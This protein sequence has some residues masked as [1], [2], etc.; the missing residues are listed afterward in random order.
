MFYLT[1]DSSEKYISSEKKFRQ[2]CQNCIL[3]VREI[4]DD[5]FFQNVFFFNL[6]WYL[7]EDF[8]SFFEIFQQNCQKWV[9]RVQRNTLTKTLSWLCETIFE[10]GQGNVWFAAGKLQPCYQICSFVS[11]WAIGRIVSKKILLFLTF[12]GRQG[13][14]FLV[15]SLY[16]CRQHG[17]PNWVPRAKRNISIKEK[18]KRKFSSFQDYERNFLNI[19]WSLLGMLSKLQ[20]ICSQKHSEKGYF[21][22]IFQICFPSLSLPTLTLNKLFFLCKLNEMIF[23][24]LQLLST[25]PNSI[26]LATNLFNCWT[27]GPWVAAQ[28]SEK[29]TLVWPFTLLNV[30]RR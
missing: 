26:A 4:F 18:F 20:F 22:R 13:N 30:K 1:S 12:F 14:I 3:N 10:F 9:L 27:Y 17:V 19:H 8:F 24:Q 16:H 2:F 23:P 29:P 21:F 7:S 5:L 25:P 28:M 15:F 11:R 6:I